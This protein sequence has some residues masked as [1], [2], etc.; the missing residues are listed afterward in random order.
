MNSKRR[1]PTLKICKG[2]HKYIVCIHTD[3]F[4][5]GK[6]SILPTKHM[7]Y[8]LLLSVCVPESKSEH[9]TYNL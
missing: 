2:S 5:R 4:P 6:N 7:D 9:L 3:G 1:E 8:N